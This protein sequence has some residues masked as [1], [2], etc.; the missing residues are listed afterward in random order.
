MPSVTA[1][2][3]AS[4]ATDLRGFASRTD[5]ILCVT[6]SNRPIVAA[7][8]AVQAIAANRV[9]RAPRDAQSATF[10]QRIGDL[11]MGRLEN[12]S[13]GS[14]RDPHALGRLLVVE[15]F[16]IGEADGLELVEGELD[17]LG[18]GTRDTGGFEEGYRWARAYVTAG[19]WAWH[20]CFRLQF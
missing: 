15:P 5:R 13:E 7:A 2:A 12:P 19:L 6:R 10:G 17:F 16:A 11:V 8:V 14:P 20:G 18:R 3:A 9:D 4:A 1:N